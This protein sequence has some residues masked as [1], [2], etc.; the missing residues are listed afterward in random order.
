M[1]LLR[2]VRFSFLIVFVCSLLIFSMSISFN[3]TGYADADEIATTA[4][5]W[6]VAHPPGYPLL[7][8]ILG[9]LMRLFPFIEPSAIANFSSAL[10]LSSALAFMAAA[11]TKTLNLFPT[12]TLKSAKLKKSFTPLV[13]ILISS[14][15]ALVLAFSATIWLFAGLSEIFAFALL[16]NAV[17]LYFV[18][19]LVTE[20]R[21]KKIRRYLFLLVFFNALSVSHL[22]SSLLLWPGLLGLLLLYSGKLKQSGLLSFKT[23]ILAL[24]IWFAGFILPNLLLFPL[25]ARQQEFS[26]Y[27]PPTV[28]G[29]LNHIFRRDYAGYFAE[30]SISRGAYLFK[31]S[32]SALT[33]AIPYY[34]LIIQ[35]LGLIGFTLFVVGLAA[36]FYYSKKLG[37]VNFL[38]YFFSGPIFAIS[39]GILPLDFNDL[40]SLLNQAVTQK[41]YLLGYLTMVP[42]IGFGLWFIFYLF[43]RLF[44]KPGLYLSFITIL[45]F[46]SIGQNLYLN[47]PVGY[48]RS[49]SLIASYAQS[50]LSLAKPNSLIICTLDIPCYS[51]FYAHLVGSM[52]EDVTILTKTSAYHRYF[53][54]NKPEFYPANN[55]AN[56][57]FM[58]N[59]VSLNL[60]KRPV[61]LTEP[62]SYYI[63]ALG[64]NADPFYLIPDNYLFEVVKR[65][66]SS[67]PE[68]TQTSFTQKVIS[69]PAS[70]KD[71]YRFG[72]KAYFSNLHQ[73]FQ[74][75]TNNYG[76]SFL[77]RKHRDFAL[78]LVPH[79]QALAA[80]LSA[81]VNQKPASNYEAEMSVNAEALFQS[82][83]TAYTQADFQQAYDLTQKL[84]LY[85]P[86]EPKY[87]AFLIFLLSQ[88]QYSD[89]A[90]K[91]IQNFQILF[92]EIE[93][94]SAYIKNTV[95]SLETKL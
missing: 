15:G 87:R 93:D 94:I 73:V 36:A 3:P 20:T 80:K 77:T 33:G 86:T 8:V 83:I 79:N 65:A 39:L 64:L 90:A 85:R 82:V 56:P 49:N 78:A 13:N 31:P 22:Q 48:Q 9:A 44:K 4:Y 47:W 51:L 35:T 24:F 6:S 55:Y 28:E 38:L 5:L 19:S 18:F 30:E 57:E 60:D 88:G 12:I 10:W 37:L 23:L 40:N 62:T 52:R 45:S 43:S 70:A 71:L 2:P 75:L 68:F 27:F 74:Q 14:T 59:L 61:Y 34:K 67:L 42:S 25:N 1:I 81:P 41:Q 7:I 53:I 16:L 63:Q 89:Q 91:Q 32:L 29:W 46:I 84:V 72:L 92:P 54:K 50:M 17:T 58:Q 95:A 69:D 26:W 76:A 66:P 21:P 11:L